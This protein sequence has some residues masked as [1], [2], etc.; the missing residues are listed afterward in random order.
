MLCIIFLIACYF[1]VLTTLFWEILLLPFPV[2]K[3]KWEEHTIGREAKVPLMGPMLWS[4]LSN[5]LESQFLLT[6]SGNKGIYHSLIY[7][8]I[9][10]PCPI[11]FSCNLHFSE[12]SDIPI[13]HNGNCSVYCT[14]LDHKQLF[15]FQSSCNVFQIACLYCIKNLTEHIWIIIL[16]SRAS[17]F[18]SVA[19]VVFCFYL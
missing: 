4:F 15:S 18:S 16:L 7:H 13:L 11:T 2:G 5:H 8:A 17:G 10:H 14:I 12:K 3:S 19:L 1:L 6:P 9:F